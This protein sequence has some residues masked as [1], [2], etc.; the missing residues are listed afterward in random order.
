[1]NSAVLSYQLRISC[2]LAGP[3][4]NT[5]CTLIALSALFLIQ[6]FTFPPFSLFRALSI[7]LRWGALRCGAIGQACVK[8]S[9]AGVLGV[10][11]VGKPL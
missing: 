2:D 8:P 5:T 6:P 4:S 3:T 11:R 10:S 9:P 7:V 1:M